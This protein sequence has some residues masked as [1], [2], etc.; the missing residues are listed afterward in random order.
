MLSELREAVWARSGGRC[1]RIRGGRRCGRLVDR[2]NWEGHV[3]HLVYRGHGAERLEDLELV[4][5]T[6]H[7]LEH[8]GRRFLDREAQL[9]RRDA[10]RLRRGRPEA[11]GQGSGP[12]GSVGSTGGPP[13]ATSHL[14]GLTGAERRAISRGAGRWAWRPPEVS[15][16]N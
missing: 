3:H 15:P 6:C 13:T 5:L 8:P 11:G 14:A 4:C 9:A 12:R 1:E 2:A 10:R 7:G 16:G